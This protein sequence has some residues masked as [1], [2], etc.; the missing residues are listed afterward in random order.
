MESAPLLGKNFTTVYEDATLGC[1]VELLTIRYKNKVVFFIT[2]IN[3]LGAVVRADIE[4][5]VKDILQEGEEDKKGVEGEEAENVNI[6]VLLG[7]RSKDEIQVCGSAILRII[8][9]Y[10][11]SKGLPIGQFGLV[12]FISLKKRPEQSEIVRFVAKSIKADIN[13]MI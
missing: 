13:K 7:D 12:C 5:D 4:Y 10:L 8:V 3:K 9:D 6:K 1:K 2:E 11:K